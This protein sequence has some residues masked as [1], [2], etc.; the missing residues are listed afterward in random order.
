MAGGTRDR[1]AKLAAKHAAGHVDSG[2]ALDLTSDERSQR[3]IWKLA[4]I[5]AADEGRAMADPP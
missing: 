2:N 5:I 1:A 4:G 3:H